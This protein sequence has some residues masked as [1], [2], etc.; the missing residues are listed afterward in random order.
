MNVLLTGANGQ[1]GRAIA[2][3]LQVSSETVHNNWIL[4]TREDL[5]VTDEETVEKYILENKI[6]I[7]VNCAAYTDVDKAEVEREKCEA[8]NSLAPGY[9]AKAASKNGALLIHFSTDYVYN[10]MTFFPYDEKRQ[11]M[12]RNY[13]GLTKLNGEKAIIDSGCSYVIFRLQ[14][15]YSKYKKNF[16]STIL[17]KAR[18]NEFEAVPVVADQITGIVSAE[19]VATHL[20]E[21]IEGNPYLP[22]R[23][24]NRGIYNFSD[25]GCASW[26]DY[27]TY[28]INYCGLAP[29]HAKPI[30]S[31]EYKEIKI[32]AADRPHYSVLSK[33][34]YQKDFYQP[35]NH[36]SYSLNNYL[37]F[38]MKNNGWN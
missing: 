37:D 29:K 38:Y 10:G 36:W 35:L 17:E 7:I 31:K 12:P 33:R 26:Y 3:A 14:G 6:N 27:A 13:Y 11:T 16:F 9:L 32:G 24:T 34:K 1:L 15:L 30:T 20:L 21:M 28:A 23:L 5:D 22:G 2:D 4:T 8:V 18:S 19:T 25:L